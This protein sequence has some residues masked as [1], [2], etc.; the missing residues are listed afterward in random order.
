VSPHRRF[1][2][3]LGCALVVTSAASFAA[4]Q[5]IAVNGP[6]ASTTPEPPSYLPWWLRG[7][8]VVAVQSRAR[9]LE[10][11][12]GGLRH[13]ST[14]R[15]AWEASFAY[16]RG[17][18][19]SSARSIPLA[20]RAIFIDSR[21]RRPDWEFWFALGPSFEAFSKDG[22]SHMRYGGEVAFAVDRRVDPIFNRFLVEI[23]LDGRRGSS[24]PWTTT[25]TLRIGIATTFGVRSYR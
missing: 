10:G 15:F 16:L 13:R 20:W 5:E 11:P 3:A 17:I 2:P 8:A 24:E 6:L 22:A 14:T 12:G 25:A 9:G 18:E 7:D 4:A 21:A 19:D 1:V 23:V